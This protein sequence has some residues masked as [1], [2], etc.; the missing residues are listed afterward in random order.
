MCHTML[1]Y[2]QQLWCYTCFF[3]W[4]RWKCLVLKAPM[5][6]CEWGSWELMRSPPRCAVD[7]EGFWNW[8]CSS[9]TVT[10]NLLSLHELCRR[11]Q[12]LRICLQGG[13]PL[14]TLRRED[15]EQTPPPPLTQDDCK[16]AQA[17]G[18]PSPVFLLCLCRCKSEWTLRIIIN[19]S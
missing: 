9:V 18:A 12:C 5:W 15:G 1:V 10:V 8:F 17:G 6:L 11:L 7:E 2:F 16:K 4:R 13:K 14:P 19:L 3:M